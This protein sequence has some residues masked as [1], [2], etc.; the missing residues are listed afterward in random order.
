MLLAKH[1]FQRLYSLSKGYRK[2]RF[3]AD[4]LSNTLLPHFVEMARAAYDSP[5][6]GVNVHTELKYKGPDE[7]ISI[8]INRESQQLILSANQVETE[9]FTRLVGS[10]V[11]INYSEKTIG[12][13]WE[14]FPD[15][16]I[17]CAVSG[18]NMEELIPYLP[19]NSEDLLRRLGFD[20][21]IAWRAGAANVF[22]PDSIRIIRI[23]PETELLN[24][25][26]A[27]KGLLSQAPIYEMQ[28]NLNRNEIEFLQW[29]DW[30]DRHWKEP[31]VSGILPYLLRHGVA[32]KKYTRQ[33]LEDIIERLLER[34]IILRT[35]EWQRRNPSHQALRLNRNHPIAIK[36]IG[37][38]PLP[39]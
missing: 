35:K 16:V 34:G 27:N 2:P 1:S 3:S 33:Q 13:R 18:L 12:V 25:T 7:E 29:F 6:Q 9:L 11:G 10:I 28:D 20:T 36:Y 26:Y 21:E 38:E 30:A 32:G 14:Q 39:R 15:E 37:P 8:V 4:T 5:Y 22:P 17:W 24:P 23:I 31:N 19:Q